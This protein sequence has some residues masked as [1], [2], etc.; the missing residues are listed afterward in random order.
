MAV[1]RVIFNLWYINAREG[2]IPLIA[3]H[4]A[5]REPRQ[6]YKRNTSSSQVWKANGLPNQLQRGP[7]LPTATR[8]M[9]LRGHAAASLKMHRPV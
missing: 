9:Q 1:H 2:I 7:R 8:G 3:P 5:V 4:A 6:Q